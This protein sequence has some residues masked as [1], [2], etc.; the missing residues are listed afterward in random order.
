MSVRTNKI[1]KELL[2]RND[3]CVTLNEPQL[4]Q[5][6]KVYVE[7]LC[8]IEKICEH[9]NVGYALSGGSLLG[10]IRHKGFIPWDDDV[11]IDVPRKDYVKLITA[12]KNEY[13]EKYYFQIPGITEDYGTMITRI[14][15]KETV[16]RNQGEEGLAE[17]GV[18]IDIVVVENTFDNIVLRKIHE[19]L[20]TVALG[21]T[22]CR[23]FYKNRKSF[24][25]L[26]KSYKEVSTI[27]R[28]KIF[29]GTLIS[30]L[31]LKYIAGFTDKV[32]A[33]CKDS[34]SKYITIP[35]GIKKFKGET[36]LRKDYCEYIK[37]DFEGRQFNIPAGYDKILKQLYGNYMEIPP[38]DK[39]E[40]HVVLEFKV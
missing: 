19:I 2:S 30:W 25:E 32:F 35:G 13:S 15:K 39:R 18:F 27:F 29:L 20:C 21:M 8:D 24:L 16:Y 11:D 4:I 33:L 6:R 26:A 7:M 22:S 36:F 12:L 5:L 28:L 10:A 37:A 23:N 34:N 40:K 9:E 14:R 1:F 38:E 17:C 31:P 3:Q